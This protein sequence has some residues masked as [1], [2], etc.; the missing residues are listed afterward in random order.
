M[1]KL[2]MHSEQVAGNTLGKERR[3]GAHEITGERC[4]TQQINSIRSIFWLKKPAASASAAAHG[5]M[6]I[7][8]K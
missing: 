8:F 7:E 2:K 3:W 6:R 5:V 1:S 4:N